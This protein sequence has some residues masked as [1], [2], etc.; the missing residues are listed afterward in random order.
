MGAGLPY[1]LPRPAHTFGF[2]AHSRLDFFGLFCS[3]EDILRIAQDV[4][5]KEGNKCYCAS[6]KN[7]HLPGGYRNNRLIQVG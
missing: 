3:T 1:N 6:G 4:W 5:E 2:C 7:Y